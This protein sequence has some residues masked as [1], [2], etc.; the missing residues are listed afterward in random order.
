M[1]TLTKRKKKYRRIREA[2]KMNLPANYHKKIA[3][4][5]SRYRLQ[6]NLYITKTI[7]ER[8]SQK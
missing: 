6:R 2:H 5:Q 1:K 4:C 8:N 3:F 7:D